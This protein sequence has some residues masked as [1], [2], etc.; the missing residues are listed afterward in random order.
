[1]NILFLKIATRYLLKNK[2]YSFINIFGLAIGVAS[3]ILIMLYVNYERSYDKFEGSDRVYRLYM[4]YLE[5]ETFISGDAQTYNLSGPTMKREF[6]EV[7]DYVRFF[8]LEKTTFVLGNRIFEQTMGSMADPS[9]FD[10]FGYPLL[11]GN[12]ETALKGPDKIVLSA[13]LAEKLFGTENPMQKNLSVFWDGEEALLTVTGVMEDIPQH[14]HFRNNYLISYETEKTWGVFPEDAISLNFNANNYYTYIKVDKNTDIDLLREKIV[15]NDADGD[16]EER[17][18]IESIEDIHLYSD[19]PYEVTAN[20]SVTRIKFLSAIAFIILIL[21]WLNYVNLSTTKSLERAK[22]TGI[23]KV[24]GAHRSQ[25]IIQSLMESMLLN[26]LAI[27]IGIIFTVIL[28]SAYNNLSDKALVLNFG[29]ISNLAPILGFILLGMLLAGLYPALLLSG[30]GPTKALK[31]EVRTSSNGIT[32]RKGLIVTQFLATIILLIGTIIVTKQINFLKDQP[33]G[34][35]LNQIIALKG[36]VVTDKSDSLLINDFKVLSAELE[37]LPFVEKMSIAQTYPGDSFDN[38]S[39]T[40]GIVLP[41]GVENENKIFYTYHV[42]PDYFDLVDISFVAGK[43]F[44]PS[45]DGN[46]RQVVVNETFLKEM[47]MKS[48]EEVIG[49]TLEFWGNNEWTITGVIK[50]YHHF[51]LKDKVLPLLIR[52]QKEVN[53][54]LVKLD[55]SATSATG[56]TYAIGQIQEKWKRMF[57]K[58]TFSYTFLDKKFEAQ[59]KEDKKFGSAFQIFTILAI[60][61]ASMGLFGLT[62]YTVVQRKKEIGIRKVNGATIT[63][64]L[65]LL[66]KDFIKWVGLAFIIAV[67]ISWYAMNKWLEGFAYKTTISWWIFVLAG[68]TAL[69]IALLTVSW[70]SFRAAIANPVDALRDE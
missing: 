26:C 15:N 19:K 33:I 27:V 23:R 70:Q 53:N 8:Y 37:E 64:I 6:P 42:Q 49:E 9:Y 16:K 67:P 58:S 47:G 1:M 63:Q 39:S 28:L 68:I 29:D 54:L 35:N 45:A 5:G 55:E 61:I 36:E 66:N 40:R 14:T 7:L 44:L 65:S 2:L 43:T 57:P 20:G 12:E 3:F 51:G 22:E 13:S 46:S 30:Y 25:L 50:D 17:H 62:A 59:Y 52:H 31:G 60:L 69:I 34:A 56:F 10:I 41:N 24:V 48:A 18:N 4:D 32:I 11:V 21:S 38:L